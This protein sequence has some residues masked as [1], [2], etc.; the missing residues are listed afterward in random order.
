MY[1]SLICWFV[2]DHEP[3]FLEPSRLRPRFD[4]PDPI[5]SS[6]ETRYHGASLSLSRSL[7]CFMYILYN[8]YMVSADPLGAGRGLYPADHYSSGVSIV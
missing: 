1:D 2:Q 7:S 8:S 5:L 4:H 6:R 3:D